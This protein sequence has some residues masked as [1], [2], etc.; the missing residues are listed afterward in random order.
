MLHLPLLNKAGLGVI[1]NVAVRAKAWKVF[2][3]QDSQGDN[4]TIF[5]SHTLEP[6]SKIGIFTHIF[7]QELYL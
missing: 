6:V 1:L 3:G 2:P 4:M 7:M 5:W